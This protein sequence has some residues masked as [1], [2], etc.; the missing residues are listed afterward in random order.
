MN[1][2]EPNNPDF[3]YQ[4]NYLLWTADTQITLTNVPWNNDYR[5]IVKF[6]GQYALDAYIDSMETTNT[7]IDDSTY[8]R[9]NQPIRLDIPF[10]KAYKY[11][12]LRASNPAKAF[13]SSDKHNFYYFITDVRYI[14]PNTTEIIVQLDIWQTFGFDVT[15]G[16]CFIE[17]G[18]IGIADSNSFSNYGRDKLTIPE[19]LDT[20]A[21][22]QIVETDRYH[23]MGAS[24]YNILVI[25]AVDLTADSGSITDPK[26]RAA[27]GG[28]INNLPTGASVYV[29]ES[30][31]SFHQ[32]LTT[33]AD[34]PWVLQ[35]ILSVTLIPRI[36]D[37][38]TGFQ[39]QPFGNP[40]EAPEGVPNKITHTMHTNWRNDANFI[41][42]II[43]QEYRHLKKF[44]TYPYMVIEI[45]TFTGQPLILKPESW[46]DND[47]RVIQRISMVPPNQRVTFHPF[48]Y[49]AASHIGYEGPNPHDGDD[50]GEYLDFATSISN[51]PTMAI[52]NNMASSYLAQNSNSIA[53]QF[54]SSDWSQQKALQGAQTGYDQASSGIDLAN[55][56]GVT[57]RN[58]DILQTNLSNKAL[59]DSAVINSL[60][61]VGSGAVMGTV[62]G[63]A[64]AAIGSLGGIT[65][66]IMGNFQAMHQQRVNSDALAIRNSANVATNSDTMNN[67]RYI[68]DTNKSLADY[69]ARGDYEN[70]IAGINAKIQDSTMAQP[71]V[72][73][74]VGGETIN[75]INNDLG[76]SVR[77]KF[78]DSAHV[79][80]I[81]DYW[82]RY[83]YA[84]SRFGN[85]PESLMV[86]TKFTYWKLSETY[87]R[88]A[89]MP[90]AFKQTIRGIF[91]KG[92]TV[93]AKPEYIGRVEWFDNEPLDGISL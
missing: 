46:A 38:I 11:N 73:G 24:L 75:I 25:S 22:Y 65:G 2:G 64:G 85:I 59:G 68:R 6:D 80:M 44:F 55:R 82:L 58:A 16:K 83:G 3:G 17:R 18:H 31:A 33:K 1:Y 63:P 32:F 40:T 60:G 47:A 8:A 27:D 74:Q 81:G 76:L 19:G 23:I 91:E 30:G 71:T 13:I 56:L 20:G 5:D 7:T 37:Y 88:S 26:L 93:W 15:L 84:V 78:M 54:R 12:Y 86:M 42:R 28:Y 69:A 79:R 51:F 45:T 4:F 21:E 70:T 90:E 36:Q 14:A 67:S 77:W 87:I 50:N 92:V 52:V 49:N 66:G 35:G 62:G 9:V 29:F 72:S 10:E 57:S 43:P 61:G 89:N 39:F 48:R 34:H 41:N 53:F